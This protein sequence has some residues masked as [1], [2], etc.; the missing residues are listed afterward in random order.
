M[1]ALAALALMQQPL[2]T[3]WTDDAKSAAIPHAE[4][5][6]P[7]MVRPQWKNLN[8]TW[9]YAI[10]EGGL[11]SWPG[12]QG[13]MRVP[14]PIES[15]L[16]GVG[17]RVP[18][19]SV[20]WQ[21]RAF[22][23]P[24]GERVMLHFGAVDWHAKV[25]VNDTL[26]GEHKGGWDPFSFDITDALQS[27]DNTLTVR[28]FDPTDAG[29]QPI[30]KQRRNNKG[31]WYTPVTGIWQT[32]W[33]EPVPE[34]H[35]IS[36]T[37]DG[38]LLNQ[39]RIDAEV[40]G[41]KQGGILRCTVKDG[42]TELSRDETVPGLPLAIGITEPKLWTPD[43][44]HLYDLIVELVEDGEVIDRVESY[45]ALRSIQL[46]K[47]GGHDRFLLNGEEIFMLG[48]LDQGWWPDGLL[49]PPTDEGLRWDIEWAKE[50]GFNCIR[51]HVKVEPARW[52]RHCDELGVLVLQDM[53][54]GFPSPRWRR[55]SDTED[56]EPDRAP[57]LEADAQFRL[58]LDEM[59]KDFR[60]FPSIVMWV[61]FNEAWGQHN[62]RATI[63][64]VMEA[65]PRRL[66]NAASGGNFVFTGHVLD[67]HAYPGP[68]NPKSPDGMASFLGEFGG[69]GLPIEK[70]LWNQ[71]ENWSYQGFETPA[72]LEERLRELFRQLH[73]MKGE[74]LAGAIYTQTTDVEIEINGLVTYDRRVEKLPR[75]TYAEIFNPL[76][77]EAPSFD[78][79]APESGE[80]TI[81]WRMT[82]NEP[83]KGW[84]GKSFD[85]TA[86]QLKPGGFGTSVTPGARV[87]TEW[88]GSEIWLRRTVI[89]P[90]LDGF[91]LKV[92][93]DEDA[94]VYLDGEL[95][96]DLKGYTTGYIFVRVNKS[97]EAGDHLLAIHCRQTTG[98]QFIDAGIYI[99][100]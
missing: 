83:A 76:Y 37:P 88:S 66:V 12:P 35:I 78:A 45:F 13:T 85:D 53:P 80:Q 22:T 25:W 38:S 98:G 27:G 1:L 50:A 29:N 34:R 79:L 4:Y 72:E 19:G 18:D 96:A 44:P 54:S 14:F 95:V 23:R 67:Q 61:P 73:I 93:H 49:T 15:D 24:R 77:E 91:W 21:H 20:L 87:G 9:Q 65:D 26:V 39:V 92:H 17:K 97:I 3:P 84:N 62:T 2:T 10:T 74:G 31:I 32:V 51:K 8:G 60:F 33:L 71:D 46:A 36:V 99:E 69:L 40:A 63:E 43:S 100:R 57:M 16:S 86:W 81:L 75:E 5:P 11:E 55:E 64:H 82:T 41:A 48:P 28:S 90:K 6:R 52:Y 68:A 42:D 47:V 7:Q 30:G 70:H 58:E 59:I 56:Q 94:Q 89:L